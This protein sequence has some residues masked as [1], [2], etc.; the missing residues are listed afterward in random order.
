M[1]F[2]TIMKTLKQ[3]TQ[4]EIVE[5][6]PNSEDCVIIVFGPKIWFKF[7]ILSCELWLWNHVCFS[8]KLD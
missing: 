1:Y 5:N 7:S 4:S 6:L 2:G 8:L 3:E